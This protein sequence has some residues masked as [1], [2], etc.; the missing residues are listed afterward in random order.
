VRP[1]PVKH[2]DASQVKVC[3]FA[4]VQSGPPSRTVPVGLTLTERRST[5]A[6]DPT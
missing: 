5:D 1:L 4:G 6:S 3:R 2:G